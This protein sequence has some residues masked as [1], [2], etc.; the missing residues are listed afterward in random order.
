MLLSVQASAALSVCLKMRT[1][2]HPHLILHELQTF[3]TLLILK[4]PKESSFISFL[5][6]SSVT[7]EPQTDWGVRRR[8]TGSV[9]ENPNLL[10]CCE[11]LIL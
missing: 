5:P 11:S 6:Q 8:G 2:T 7:T 10:F 3:F 9:T 4:F 1:K